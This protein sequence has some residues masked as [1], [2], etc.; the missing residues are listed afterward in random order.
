[1]RRSRRRRGGGFLLFI[2]A[3]LPLSL[4]GLSLVSDYAVTVMAHRHVA[5]GA[6]SVAMAAGSAYSRTD[7]RVLDRPESERR[8]REMFN[9]AVRTGMV[10]RGMFSELQ[11]SSVQFP[12]PGSVQVTISYRT[13]DLFISSFLSGRRLSVS[14][15]VTRTAQICI[16]TVTQPCAYPT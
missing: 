11:L 8:A 12:T 5:T 14:G 7:A 4:V 15:Q 2:L 1:M 9:E 6:D 13:P 16:T 3:L 10:P